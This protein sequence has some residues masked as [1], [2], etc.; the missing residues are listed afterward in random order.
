MMFEETIL[1][2]FYAMSYCRTLQEQRPG[3]TLPKILT[4]VLTSLCHTG[5]LA[6]LRKNSSSRD[7]NS[8][9][10]KKLQQPPILISSSFLLGN[11]GPTGDIGD[12][13][14]LGKI[15]PIGGKGKL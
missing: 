13:G 12:Q 11:K 9:P 15:G 10:E 1:L 5:R 4:A 8:A 2:R 3:C 6:T 7:L 14:M